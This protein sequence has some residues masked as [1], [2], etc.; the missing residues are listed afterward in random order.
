MRSKPLTTLRV[1]ELP[2]YG[3]TRLSCS[4]AV[5]D[6]M[7]QDGHVSVSPTGRAG[8]YKLRARHKVGVLRYDDVEVRISPKLPISR[9]LYLAGF[10]NDPT[11]W[12]SI[13]TLLDDVDDPLSAVAHALTH[14]AQVALNPAPLQGY[15]THERADRSV[16]GR[17]YFDRQLSRQ[18]GLLT[19][20]ELR[21]DEYELDIAENRVLKAALLLIRRLPLDRSLS[22][23][24]RHQLGVLDTVRPW[25]AGVPV[26]EF[27]FNRLNQ[28]Y[29]SALAV[30]RLVLNRQSLE[31]V[32]RRTRGTA[33]LFNMNSVFERY[34]EVAL[35]RAMAEAGGSVVGQHR[36][37]L[38]HG[39]Q[40][41]MKPDLTWWMGG[42]CRAVIDAKYK[43]AV[44]ADY[45]NVDAYQMLAYCTRLGLERGFLVYADMGGAEPSRSVVRNVGVEIVAAAIDLGGSIDDLDRSVQSLADEIV[46]CGSLKARRYAHGS[47]PSG[48][49]V[50]SNVAGT[51]TI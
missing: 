12:R 15:V 32:Q 8:E 37:H 6:R 31:F 36:V 20:I 25:P 14:H 21:F 35:R 41:A 34:L 48:L 13:E 27:S 18:K 46:D 50:S 17:I 49:I 11:A 19:P 44:N 40:L 10:H 4:L 30:A 28:R 47:V 42:A 39:H 2:E 33:F 26:P 16:R 51:S 9:L 24:V 5:A 1:V 23:I 43:R 22:G 38:D 29:R 45:P 3:E 7:H